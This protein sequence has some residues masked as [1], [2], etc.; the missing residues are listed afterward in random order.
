MAS[1]RIRKAQ[2]TIYAA[3][4]VLRSSWCRH[5]PLTKAGEPLHDRKVVID[6]EVDVLVFHLDWQFV[7]L[8]EAFDLQQ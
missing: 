1:C 2:E 7:V 8:A 3:Q 4:Q 6:R 5:L